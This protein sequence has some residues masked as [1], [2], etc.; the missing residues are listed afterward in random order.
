LQGQEAW[1]AAIGCYDQALALDPSLAAAHSNRGAALAALNRCDEAL[2]SFDRAI[3]L[4]PDY[5]EAHFS[6]AVTLLLQGNL[7]AGWIEFEW[8][9]KTA[10]GRAL[11]CA[12]DFAQPLWLGAQ[13]IAGKTLLLHCERGLGDTLQFCRYARNVS[14]LEAKVILQVQAPLLELLR[15]LPAAIQVVGETEALP[16]FDL[17]CPLLSLPLAF[18]TSL[19]TIPAPHRYLSADVAKVLRLQCKLGRPRRPRIGLVW[20]G[21]ARNPDDRR[22]SV[23]LHDLLANLPVHLEYFSLQ[24]EIAPQEALQ[25]QGQARQARASQSRASQAQPIQTH[26]QLSVLEDVVMDFEHTAALCECLDLVISIDSSVA[27]LAAALGRTTWILLP[28]NPD[29]RWLLDRNDSPWYPSVRLYRQAVP[30]DWRTVLARVAADLSLK[31][32]AV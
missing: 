32:P 13:P 9:W 4:R 28:F 25:I 19:G 7:A 18:R 15:R 27:H 16:H 22:R 24:K 14:E 5:P 2:A 10:P 11:K 8:R 31:W 30:G 6:R 1:E 3:S 17:Q 23:A 29:C 26:A 20:R 21:D 12:K